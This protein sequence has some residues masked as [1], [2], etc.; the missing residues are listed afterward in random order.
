MRVFSLGCFTCSA[1]FRVTTEDAVEAAL[2]AGIPCVSFPRKE[3]LEGAVGSLGGCQCDHCL[4]CFV[5]I[6][7]RCSAVDLVPEHYI[8]IYIYI[9][10][11]YIYMYIDSLF[12]AV[13]VAIQ[14]TS[15]FAAK[16]FGAAGLKK[17]GTCSA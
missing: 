3:V 1:C 14:V 10:Y 9:L 13:S 11:I 6:L 15:G 12:L 8:Y 7:L 5:F 16:Y 17:D 2:Q 4:F